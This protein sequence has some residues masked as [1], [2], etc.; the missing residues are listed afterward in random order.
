MGS[1]GVT[2]VA[3][4]E[5]IGVFA[6][7]A[8]MLAVP[9]M[10]IRRWRRP[11][12]CAERHDGAA[13]ERARHGDLVSGRGSAHP[14]P[15]A[16]SPRGNVSQSLSSPPAAARLSQ[17]TL[18]PLCRYVDFRR[19]LEL[20]A[21]ELVRGLS[22]LP[23]D[24]WRIEPYPLTGD[25][26]NTLMVLGATGVFV[27][28]ATYPPGSWDD[29]TATSRLARKLQL[30]LPGY[31]GEVHAAICHPFSSI[32][33]RRWHRPDEHGEW[34]G[35]WL[36]GGDSVIEWLEHFGDVHGFSPAD[37]VRF[38]RLTEPNW[39]G[40]AIPAAPTWPPLP[41]APSRSQQ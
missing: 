9:V 36:V 27:I 22:A 30:L 29:I 16:P 4:P 32:R 3:T 33:P 11:R 7:W 28:V 17:G 25:R 15:V 2:A 35:S 41:D 8:V 40:P 10:L 19:R 1:V 14:G 20:A 26:R 31:A 34:C 37:L 39:L 21:A 23:R 13:A 38:D 24:R 12:H 6:W 5:L 18:E